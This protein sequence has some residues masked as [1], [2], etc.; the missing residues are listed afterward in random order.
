MTKNIL[1]GLVIL[2]GMTIPTA[3]RAQTKPA[4]ADY[5]LLQG[6]GL[7]TDG[8]ALLDYFRQRTYKETDPAELALLIKQLGSDSFAERDKAH[9]DLL[10][11]GP[12]AVVGLK[13]AE[14]HPDTEVRVRVRDIRVQILAKVDPTIQAA[15]ARLIAALKPDGAAE[16][17]LGYIPFAPDQAVVD[18]LCSAVSDVAMK[19]GRPE[20]A[21]VKSLTDPQTFQRIAAAEALVRG[22]AKEH[23]PAVRKLL[24]DS[25]DRVRL[26]VGLA[27]VA[28]KEKEALPVLV[29]LLGSPR[30]HDLWKVEEVLVRL[31][32]ANVPSVSLGN[33]NVDRKKCRDAWNEW[34]TKQG[35]KIDLAKL[36][37][38]QAMLGYTLLVQQSL[39]PRVGRGVTGEVLEL[40]AN[41]KERW[42]F[43]VDGYPVDA[44]VIRQDR[45]LVAEYNRNKVTERDFQ[46]NIKWE[47]NVPGQPIGVQGLPNGNVFVVMQFQ[48]VEY[49]R[50]HKI[51]FSFNRNNNNIFRARKM[52]NGD[53]VLITSTGQLTRIDPVKQT[54]VK[55]FQVGNLGTLYGSID[56]LPDGGVLVPD[57]MQNRV[58]EY[59]ADGK[60]RK[61][62][63][64]VSWP[65]SVMRLPNGN[66]LVSSQNARTIVEFDRTGT[67]VMRITTNN[68]VFNARRR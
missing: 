59:D 55:S 14:D 1:I 33:T 47:Q 30:V 67:E 25:D 23:F 51:V 38:E 20:A 24:K 11:L 19:N 52:R 39:T 21:V 27:L 5:R 42:K 58:V 40:D 28:V 29:D 35:D 57:Y 44:F 64:G 62:F 65:N 68:T 31:A 3:A 26:H 54:N 32:G 6:V 37:Q 12:P 7:K 16:V 60:Q 43:E 18:E 48:L 45:V 34:L 17:L 49:D 36:D 22:K 61:Q 63:G 8:P 9:Q 41:K 15:T 53:V 4:D 66:T 50:D 2:T 13:Q 46:G 56:V 10:K